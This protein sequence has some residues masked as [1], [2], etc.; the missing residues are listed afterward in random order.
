MII[1]CR[2]VFVALCLTWTCACPVWGQASNP[3]FS[4]IGADDAFNPEADYQCADGEASVCSP[5]AAAQP[6][7]FGGPCNS[8]PKLTGD[9]CCLREDFRECG[10]TL[11]LSTTT[12]YQG[13]ATGG[14]Q[15]TFEFGGRNDYLL[16]VDGQKAGLWQGLGINVHG[17]TVYGDS[18][19]LLT[20]AVV[21][22]NIGRSL[23]VVDGDVSALTAFKFT[24]ALSEKLVLFAGKI[25]TVDNL[26]QPFMPGRG[27]DA[28][29]MNGAFVFNPVLGRTIPYSTFGA[30]APSW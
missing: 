12:Y 22:V 8:R 6:P 5:N 7:S 27:L 20:G 29:F 21:P 11:D 10:Y 4:Y 18:V 26:Q 28:G 25:N 14:L 1:C 30:G 23:P 2:L 15:E 16:N 9:W 17:E 3:A 19:N 13:I 24:Q